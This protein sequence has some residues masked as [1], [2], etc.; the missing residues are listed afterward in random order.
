MLFKKQNCAYL[1]QTYLIFNFQKKCTEF[2]FI[3]FIFIKKKW[4][5]VKTCKYSLEWT[6]SMYSPMKLLNGK[7]LM[8]IMYEKKILSQLAWIGRAHMKNIDSFIFYGGTLAIFLRSMSLTRNKFTSK[9]E[10][11]CYWCIWVAN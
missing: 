3:Q 4:N 11:L 5:S 7:L 8:Q 9:R 6:V 2:L 1:L 10:Q